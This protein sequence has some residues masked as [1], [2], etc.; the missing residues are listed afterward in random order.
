MNI[1]LKTIDED[2][3]DGRIL[4]TTV[5]AYGVNVYKVPKSMVDL[6]VAD[7]YK[8]SGIYFLVNTKKKMV[9]VGK[10]Q[11]RANG[12]GIV[13][14]A[15]EK[16]VSHESVGEWDYLVFVTASESKGEQ[17]FSDDTLGYMEFKFYDIIKNSTAK[18]TYT[19]KNT[20]SYREL[21][22][23]EPYDKVVRSCQSMFY[24]LGF[25]FLIT[26]VK[27]NINDVDEKFVFKM[28]YNGLVAKLAYDKNN[29]EYILLKDS[30][31]SKVESPSCYKW[32]RES[33][34][35]IRKHVKAGKLQKNIS[36][37]N[38]SRAAG[39]VAGA[40]MN[41]REAWKNKNGESLGEVNKNK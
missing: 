17:F 34:E 39:V 40:S 18:Y 19:N 37:D 22:D 38:P 26:K 11:K 33:R 25:E 5:S 3:V 14:R 1:N 16:D 2:R 7:E 6:C 4:A 9:Y 24:A 35:E 27:F 13:N 41:G 29:N 36:F 23:K 31:I 32:I 20:P 21:D 10:A 28:E 12:E 30:D 15:N 8:D